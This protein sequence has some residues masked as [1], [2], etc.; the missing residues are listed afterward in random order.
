MAPS[1]LQLTGTPFD[2]GFQHGR[3]APDAIR[4][5]LGLYFHRFRDEV[6][7]SPQQ[8]RERAGAYPTVLAADCRDYLAALQGLA[9]GSGCDLL[10]LAVLN[11]R[12][13]ILYSELSAR[14]MPDG[15]TALAVLPDR[16]ADGHLLLA[17]NWDWI[18]EVQPLVLHTPD[19]DG[20]RT[21][22]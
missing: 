18:P 11:A 15:C 19:P 3:R 8:V 17:Q 14:A 12:Y 7:L 2:Q 5:N 20:L 13:E 4:H 9:D 10:D 21:V 16:S 6:G 22:S 1:L